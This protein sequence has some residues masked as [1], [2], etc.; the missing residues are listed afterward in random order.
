MKWK[1]VAT[2]GQGGTFVVPANEGLGIATSTPTG[3][4]SLVA[5]DSGKTVYLDAAEGFDISLPTLAAG[6]KYKF[7][8]ASAFATTA[9]TVAASTNV[10]QGGAI[11]NSVYVP[12][13]NENTISFV[14]T[15]ETVGDYVEVE[16]DGTNWYVNGVGAL[17]GSITFTAP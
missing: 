1:S 15:A 14:A 8:V 2:D 10:I 4:T 12:A 5:K 3:S 6:L 9:F 16:C 13:V 17:A 7:V 11:V